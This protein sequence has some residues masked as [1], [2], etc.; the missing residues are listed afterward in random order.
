MLTLEQKKLKKKILDNLVLHSGDVIEAE[1]K[2][3]ATNKIIP[4]F[5]VYS[6]HL[7]VHFKDN[8][9][10]IDYYLTDTKG[11]TFDAKDKTYFGPKEV[12]AGGHIFKVEYSEISRPIMATEQEKKKMYED[13]IKTGKGKKSNYFG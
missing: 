10:T 2:D 1:R 13:A 5:G 12:L 3:A 6:G 4:V 7:D 8:R 9:V 11:N